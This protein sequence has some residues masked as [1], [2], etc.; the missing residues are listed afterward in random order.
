[1]KTTKSKLKKM[2]KEEAAKTLQEM[3][4]SQQD[5][6]NMSARDA[7]RVSGGDDRDLRKAIADFI[8]KGGEDR[9]E[10][11]AQA[12]GDYQYSDP[13]L[14]NLART[15][16]GKAL[17]TSSAQKRIQVAKNVEKQMNEY[18]QNLH[19]K[20][21]IKEEVSKIMSEMAI[22]EMAFSLDDL[23][24]ATADVNQR[25]IDAKAQKNGKRLQGLFN[26]LRNAYNSA[27]GTG[28]VDPQATRKAHQNVRPVYHK[29][30]AI[31]HQV[32]G[33]LARKM[34]KGDNMVAL[35]L[36]DWE[37]THHARQSFDADN[38]AVANDLN[39]K[40]DDGLTHLFQSIQAIVDFAKETSDIPAPEFNE[41]Y[42]SSE[43]AQQ[44]A[45]L[46]HEAEVD[47]LK[48]KGV[49]PPPMPKQFPGNQ[50]YVRNK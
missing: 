6:K 43:N 14:V 42:L 35:T 1:M 19:L 12:I 16:L 26:D 24:S 28:V 47:L 50:P 20:D 44:L 29:N 10:V 25:D 15:L 5:F 8:T 36:A 7:L 45:K 48:P 39:R 4:V 46:A 11:L 33:N 3:Q 21:I 9:Q 49:N 2:L 17:A 27:G 30:L 37:R 40:L 23:E 38:D 31:I 22:D 32:L 13:Y 34:L 18:I 41:P